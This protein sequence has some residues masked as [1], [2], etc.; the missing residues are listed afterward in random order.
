MKF[1][2]IDPT[3]VHP[4]I[5]VSKE[6]PP[7]MATRSNRTLAAA[8]GEIMTGREIS[9]GR[10]TVRINI[11]AR[12]PAEAWEAREKL[13]AWAASS[14]EGTGRL[15][16]T[17]RPGRVYEA[18]VE[19][20]DDPEFIR[21]FATVDVVFF[22]PRPITSSLATSYAQG[23][24]ELLAWI[25]GSYPARPAIRQTLAQDC[26]RVTWTMDGKALLEAEGAFAVG[27]VIE[28]DTAKEKVTIGGT[29]AMTAINPQRTYWRPGF[30]PGTHAIASTD[31]GTMEMRWHDEWL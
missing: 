14:G 21:G 29:V 6:I 13:A 5:R 4:A 11:A 7:G 20:I 3:T 18:A 2:G 24:G 25:G 9:A 10:Y 12:T 16:P 15:E 22:L 27:T 23:G 26:E 8:D 28:M 17:H 1:N 19:T 31:G 30:T